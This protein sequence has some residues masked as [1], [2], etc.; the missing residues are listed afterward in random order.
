MEKITAISSKTYD[1]IFAFLILLLPVSKAFPN[2]VLLVLILNFF[3]ISKK[4]DYKNFIKTPFVLITILVLYL[5]LKSLFLNTLF[6]E[7]VFYKKYLYLFTVPIL[8][9]KVNNKQLIKTVSI[10]TINAAIFFSIY[11]ILKF[12]YYFKYL[13]FD[14]GWATNFVLVFERPYIGILSVI[15]ILLSIE[16]IELK[17]KGKYFFYASALISFSFIFFISI[18][19]SIFTLFIIFLLYCGFYLKRGKQKKILL[20][21]VFFSIFSISLLLNNTIQKRFLIGD[22]YSQTIKNIQHFE[23]RVVIWGCSKEVVNQDYFSKIIGSNSYTNM[24]STLKECYANKVN[25]FSRK[26][27]FLERGFN[28]HNQFIDFYLIGGTIAIILFIGFFVVYLIV[29]HKNYYATA[30]II[31]FLLFLV[32]ENMFH[33]Q[34]GCFIFTIFTPL[35]LKSN[36]T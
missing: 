10:I 22:T 8:L 13:P 20:S 34:F 9:M 6:D 33:R 27:W 3:L 28:T 23:P 5:I 2:I 18:R 31:A 19:A 36:N 25:D 35:F 1:Y 11:K 17:T 12:Y 29:N 24:E 14:D 4:E 26:Q 15:C 30:I 7:I 21:I 16:Q 32:V